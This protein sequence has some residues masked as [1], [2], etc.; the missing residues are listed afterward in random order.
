[1]LQEGMSSS[2]WNYVCPA[3]QLE[4]GDIRVARHD[5]SATSF[6]RFSNQAYLI[7]RGLKL[8]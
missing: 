8:T 2:V 3:I 7:I 4:L 1:M 6:S 5:A